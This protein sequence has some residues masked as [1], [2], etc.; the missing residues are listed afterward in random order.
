MAEH[1]LL[2]GYVRLSLPL[3][4]HP[5]RYALKKMKEW[6]QTPSTEYG[7]IRRLIIFKLYKNNFDCY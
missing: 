1:E 5:I 7:D 3:N 2:L 6:K 4:V